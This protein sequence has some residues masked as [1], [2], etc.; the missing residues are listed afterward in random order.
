[1]QLQR[2]NVSPQRR[3]PDS[4]PTGLCG[5]Y[6]G[7]KSGLLGR[8][9]SS[10]IKLLEAEMRANGDAQVIVSAAVEEH[11]VAGFRAKWVGRKALPES[12][13][14][15]TPDG[16]ERVARIRIGLGQSL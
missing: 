11:I 14:Q 4:H 1:M 2:A 13:I 12:G 9:Q 8:L 3:R 7:K 6:W 10:K 16:L 15:Q 5:S